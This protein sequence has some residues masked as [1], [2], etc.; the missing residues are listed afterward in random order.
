MEITAISTIVH[1]GGVAAPGESLVVSEEEGLRLC[2]IGAAFCATQS[3]ADS[4]AGDETLESA[5]LSPVESKSRKGKSRK[6][7]N[8]AGDGLGAEE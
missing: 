6:S 8:E 3:D 2:T 5:D 7:K 4:A 1:D